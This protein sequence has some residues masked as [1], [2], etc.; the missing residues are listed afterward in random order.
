L[1]GRHCKAAV[2]LQRAQ[3]SNVDGVQPANRHFMLQLS[4]HL[5][6]MPKMAGLDNMF[7]RIFGRLTA[8]IPR[9]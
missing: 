4:P 3:D 9:I 5:A 8:M 2:I 1:R 7:G 6:H